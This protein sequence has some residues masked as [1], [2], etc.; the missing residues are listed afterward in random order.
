MAN[1]AVI[2]MKKISNV[3][4]VLTYKYW[5]IYNYKATKIIQRFGWK[6]MNIY[7]IPHIKMF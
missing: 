7:C 3:K 2:N 1:K 6:R 5:N 4:K